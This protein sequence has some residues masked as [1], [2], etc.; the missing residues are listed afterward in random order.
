MA[1]FLKHTMISTQAKA[2]SNYLLQ[3]KAI[4]LSPQNPFTWASG[5]KSPIYCD[6]RLV[7]SYPEVRKLAI[8]ALEELS[9]Q[10]SQIDVIAGVATAGIPHGAILADHLNLPF[11]Y[12]RAKA[13]EHG[14]QNLIEGAYKSGQKV[15][16]IEDLISTGGSSLEAIKALQSEGLEI[17]ACLALFT[18]QFKESIS[19]FSDQN[20]PLGT[21]TD[22]SHVLEQ[23][24][25]NKSI[26]EK[27]HV[28][29]SEWKND[30]SI[31]YAK[32]FN[33]IMN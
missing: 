29:L 12:V 11:I 13:K 28:I 2:F 3:I 31:W 22:Y 27:E 16:V 24:L 5:I 18:Y 7:L 17:A 20:I 4:Q 25:E 33:S 8:D 30:P 21:V 9:K 32:N 1:D 6:N 26:T 23:A 15:L 10:H 14:K 19:R